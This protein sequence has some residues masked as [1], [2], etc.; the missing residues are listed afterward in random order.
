VNIVFF[1]SIILKFVNKQ[2]SD[3]NKVYSVIFLIFITK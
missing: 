1:V 2:K 3:K